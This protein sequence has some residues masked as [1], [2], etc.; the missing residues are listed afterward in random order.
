LERFG[1][2]ES[3]LEVM[4]YDA[5]AAFVTSKH[6]FDAENMVAEKLT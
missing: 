5:E 1:Y 6:G 3:P 2:R 4:A